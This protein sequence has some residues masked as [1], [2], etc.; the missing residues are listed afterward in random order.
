MKVALSKPL[1]LSVWIVSQWLATHLPDTV[2]DHVEGAG[3]ALGPNVPFRVLRDVGPGRLCGG[4]DAVEV[5]QHLLGLLRP[6][7][8]VDDLL[9][10]A[11]G[12]RHGIV[13]GVLLFPGGGKD[14][15]NRT[16]M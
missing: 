8:L 1:C 13:G 14:N 15:R 6:A 7:R 12:D 3:S 16:T 11:G 5:L 10:E 2:V 9:D 4:L